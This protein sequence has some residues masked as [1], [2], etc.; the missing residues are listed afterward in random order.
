M[1]IAIDKRHRVF[2]S[3]S[4]GAVDGLYGRY[5]LIERPVKSSIY[6]TEE[7]GE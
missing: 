1:D 7:A 6:F 4:F 3:F 5:F 2:T